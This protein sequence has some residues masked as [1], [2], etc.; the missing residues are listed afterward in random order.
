[1][2]S[3]ICK[4]CGKTILGYIN[5]EEMRRANKKRVSALLAMGHSLSQELNA[6]QWCECRVTT[7]D[8]SSYQERLNADP[9]ERPGYAVYTVV[10]VAHDGRATVL[11]C[12]TDKDA[13]EEVRYLDKTD[14]PSPDY[15]QF[16]KH[17]LLEHVF[18]VPQSKE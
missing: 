5:T 2:P 18:R 10:R 4:R 14:D 16:F 1:M 17:D 3:V 13:A 8:G 6:E 9:C 15:G 12:G 11:Y 7:V